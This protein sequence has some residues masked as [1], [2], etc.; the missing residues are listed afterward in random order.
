MSKKINVAILT[1]NELHEAI[2]DYLLINRPTLPDL[3]KALICTTTHSDGSTE[4]TWKVV[5][6]ELGEILGLKEKK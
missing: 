4:F 1:T 2:R 6:E 3:R 5:E